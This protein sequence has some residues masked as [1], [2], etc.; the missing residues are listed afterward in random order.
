MN[1]LIWAIILS[2]LPISE[3]RGGIPLAIGLGYK[4]LL[5]FLTCTIANS[6]IVFPFF[7]FLDYLNNYFMR[8]TR[9]RNFFNKYL[10]KKRGGLEKYIG[11]KG[12]FIALMIFV[13]IPLPGTG[14]YTGTLLAW[15]FKMK[16]IYS[17]IAIIAGVIIAGILI[18]LASIGI[19][20]FFL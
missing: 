6:L 9:Y 20:T 13:G 7:F 16:R 12:E 1:N 8:F 19:F 2:V 4:P 17:Y 15:F 3:L 14:A 18:T 5:V 10:E 11:K